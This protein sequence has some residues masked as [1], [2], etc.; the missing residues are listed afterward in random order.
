MVEVRALRREEI[1]SAVAL[2]ARGFRD[3]PNPIAA[4][5]D[6][7]ARR[8]RCLRL[9]FGGLFR[10]MQAQAPLVALED[11]TM[12]GVTGIAPP[13]ACQP[14]FVQQ[15]RMVVSMLALGPRSI[16]RLKRWFGAWA[17]VDPDE[18]HSH[19]GPLAVAAHL[20]GRGIGSRILRVYSRQLDKDGITGYLETETE[21]NV[22]LYRRFGFEIVDER[23]V[24]GQPNWFMRRAALAA[25]SE[26]PHTW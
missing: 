13:G 24:L 4:F 1:P 25:S 9:V 22:R 15:V 23:T 12:V 14:D 26:L 7:P 6:D 8:Q 16:T 3:N 5:G 11:G 20:R 18:P 21:A 19:L 10:V 17:A 2:L